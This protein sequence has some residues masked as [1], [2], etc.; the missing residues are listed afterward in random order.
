MLYYYYRYYE[1]YYKI[2]IPLCCTDTMTLSTPFIIIIY[3]T[4]HS[5]LVTDVKFEQNHVAGFLTLLKNMCVGHQI[6]QDMLH[7]SQ[8]IATIGALLQRVNGARI[9]RRVFSV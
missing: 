2:E 4:F 6:N 1:H 7:K 8:G 9:F 5:L 3:F